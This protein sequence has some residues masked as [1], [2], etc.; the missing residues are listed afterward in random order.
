MNIIDKSLLLKK[1]SIQ[2]NIINKIKNTTTAELAIVESNP[3]KLVLPKMP[4]FLTSFESSNI[5]EI[6]KFQK[7]IENNIIKEKPE[8]QQVLPV[9]IPSQPQ[10]NEVVTQVQ[11]VLPVTIPSQPQINDVV[12]Q[13]QQVLPVAIP[14]QPQ[15]NEV[16]SQIQQVLPVT[17]PSQ[18]QINEVVSQNN[19][20]P[21]MLDINAIIES[22]KEPIAL[23]EK[24]ILLNAI[25]ANINTEELKKYI[26]IYNNITSIEDIKNIKK[27]GYFTCFKNMFLKK[28][29]DI[30]VVEVIEDIE[31]IKNT[32][33]FTC[34]KK[35]LTN[36]KK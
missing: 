4:E 30:D 2:N 18:P 22:I 33:C 27:T 23:L 19:I 36:K 25:P 24:C 20:I 7:I 34:F 13:I 16:V 21:E 8:I 3:P 1:I 17:I 31:E 6:S 28:I 29:E 5:S 11:Q 12:S 26:N 14:S 32:G 9:A 10:I 15:I 35:Y